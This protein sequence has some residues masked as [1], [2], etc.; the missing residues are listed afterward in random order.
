MILSNKFL[1]AALGVSIAGATLDAARADAGNGGGIVR[2]CREQVT[3][4][5][6]TD[7]AKIEAELKKCRADPNNYK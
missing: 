7:A 5:K 2:W 3:N 4:K 6:I 1:V